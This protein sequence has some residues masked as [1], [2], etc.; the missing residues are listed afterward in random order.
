[1]FVDPTHVN[2]ITEHTHEYFSGDK[3]LG[4]IYGFEGG[5]RALRTEWVVNLDSLVAQP[6][7][8]RQSLRRWNRQRSGKLTHFLWELEALKPGR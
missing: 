1:V 8:L 4:R 3:P 7:T 5:F 2:F 6:R